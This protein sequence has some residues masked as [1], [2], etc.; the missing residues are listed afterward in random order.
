M[1]KRSR[2]HFEVR[3]NV[4]DE[5]SEGYGLFSKFIMVTRGHDILL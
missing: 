3:E 2:K 4:R 5:K 1:I